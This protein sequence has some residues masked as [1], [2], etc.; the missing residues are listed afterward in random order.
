MD[1]CSLLQLSDPQP[2][3]E[4]YFGINTVKL[5]VRQQA[6]WTKAAAGCSSPSGEKQ[7]RPL[8][9]RVWI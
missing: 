4:S 8:R 5:E 6:A 3:V 7:T 2:A 9:D 1:C